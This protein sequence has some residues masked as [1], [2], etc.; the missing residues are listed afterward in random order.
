MYLFDLHTHNTETPPSVIAIHN[1]Y[2]EALS[3]IHQ[4]PNPFTC[5]IHPW[6]INP[7]SL[8]QSYRQTETLLAQPHCVAV[9]EAGLDKNCTTPMPIQLDVFRQMIAYSEQYKKPLIIHCVKAFDQLLALHK[10]LRPAQPWIIHGFRGKP[11]LARQ[12][13]AQG[14]YLSFGQQFNEQT[15]CGV[16]ADRFFLET[17]DKVF[18]ISALYQQVA[19][20]RNMPLEQLVAD[21]NLRAKQLF[22]LDLFENL[23]EK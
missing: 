15:V 17:D 10:Q 23:L 22:G 18:N 19:E 2:P 1:I 4:L 9:G 14:F 13:V 16:D 20:L 7:D 12:L 5:G 8:P 6:F 3:D 21:I 11:E